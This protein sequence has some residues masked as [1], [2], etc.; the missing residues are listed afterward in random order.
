MSDGP[1]LAAFAWSI[2]RS[3][4]S[5]RI[6]DPTGD[7]RWDH[8]RLAPVLDRIREQGTSALPDLVPEIRAYLADASTARPDDLTRAEALAYWINVYNAA[9]LLL[10]AEALAKDSGSVLRIPGAFSRPVL[11]IDGEDLSLDAVEHA[12]V[13]RFRDPRIHAALVC[14]SVSCPTLRAEPYRAIDLDETLDTQLRTL[15]AEGGAVV[16]RS[17]GRVS[18]SKIF[19]W[20]GGDFARPHRMPTLRPAGGPAVLASLTPWLDEATAHWVADTSPAVD[21]LPYDW[22]VACTVR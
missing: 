9:A 21:F 19:N 18:L 12:K 3:L 1:N 20:Y 13:R 5:I 2:G 6:P 7:G 16:D 17:G 10:A 4:L 8:G 22:T 11:R 15:L 14:G